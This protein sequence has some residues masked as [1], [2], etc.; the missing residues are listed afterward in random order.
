M[1]VGCTSMLYKPW[2]TGIPS[3]KQTRYE[4]IPNCTYCPV[5][6]SYN[7]CNIIEL[8]PKSTPFEA[9]DEI[10]QVVLD[11]ISENMAS[12]FKSG[13][14]GAINIDDTTTNGLYVIQFL[15]EA[16]TLQNNTTISGQINSLVNQFS[17]HN[18]FDPC[19]KTPICIGNNN[20]CNRPLNLSIH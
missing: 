5:M 12:L 4:P 10:D 17:G 11:V 1:N 16:Y 9:F 13:M 6:G 18:I 20:H 2:I 7:N 14:Y 8:T 15:S 3:K 19:K